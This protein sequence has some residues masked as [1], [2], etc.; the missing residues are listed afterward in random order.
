[1]ANCRMQDLFVTNALFLALIR[2]AAGQP[3][4][5]GLIV[6]QHFLS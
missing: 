3:L 6:S 2:L 4:D 5:L 1:M